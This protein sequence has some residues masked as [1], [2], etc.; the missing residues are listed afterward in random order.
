M[1]DTQASRAARGQQVERMRLIVQGGRARRGGRGGFGGRGASE[2]EQQKP[3]TCA[4]PLSCVPA[5]QSAS[6]G[7]RVGTLPRGDTSSEALEI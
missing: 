2:A 3:K 6:S 7:G 1:E 5:E 4:L